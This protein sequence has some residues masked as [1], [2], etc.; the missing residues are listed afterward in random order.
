MGT[1]H[2]MDLGIWEHCIALTGTMQIVSYV[3][4]NIHYH[5]HYDC[6]NDYHYYFYH[7]HYDYDYSTTTT[8]TGLGTLH[9]MGLGI[10]EH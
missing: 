5:Y 10:W 1:W 9:H 4:R 7:Y 2:H 3:P 8:R 6:D